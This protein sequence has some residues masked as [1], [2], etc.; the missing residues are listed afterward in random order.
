MR[1]ACR[2]MACHPQLLGNVAFETGSSAGLG[3][4]A[5]LAREPR[6]PVA[7]AS[8]ALGH[9]GPQPDL[10]SADAHTQS[11]Y[12]C[13]KRLSPEPASKAITYFHENEALV[14]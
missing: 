2:D 14:C 3:A 12:L 8:P 5:Q 11:L 10:C 6:A 13:I 4:H 9:T 7:S 1:P